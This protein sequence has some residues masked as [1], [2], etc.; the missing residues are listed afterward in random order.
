MYRGN[1][2][3]PIQ[4][5]PHKPF[6][7]K[8]FQYKPFHTNRSNTNRSTTQKEIP[9]HLLALGVVDLVLLVRQE[10]VED[11]ARG[12]AAHKLTRVKKTNF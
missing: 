5:V 6:R 11:H 12:V 1:K 4:T 7:Y 8:P 9:R 2:T 3:V 10:L